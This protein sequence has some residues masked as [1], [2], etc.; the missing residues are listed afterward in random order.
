MKLYL[1]L[2]SVPEL[3]D[4]SPAQR[5]RVHR[6]C[7]Q[8]HAGG[9]W[10]VWIANLLLGLCAGCGLVAGRFA[11]DF[12]DIP[13]YPAIIMGVAMGGAFG[14]L[15]FR[16]IVIGYLRAYYSEGIQEVLAQQNELAK[17]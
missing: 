15:V 5:L 6:I 1:R 13:F 17:H 12:T 16:K 9:A 4:L 8:R 3:K 11:S 14:F 10:Q 2:K 7:Y